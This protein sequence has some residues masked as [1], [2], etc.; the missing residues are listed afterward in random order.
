[1]TTSVPAAGKSPFAHLAQSKSK[2]SGPDDVGDEEEHED[3]THDDADEDDDDDGDDTDENGKKTKKS[4][5]VKKAEDDSDDKDEDKP[6]AS[7]ARRREKARIRTIVHSA[8]GK[9][10]PAAAL[11]L[12]LSS[13]MPRHAAVRLLARMGADIP[14]QGARGLRD[15]MAGV[16]MPEIGSDPSQNGG[17][18]PTSSSAAQAA[19]IIAAGRKARG[20]K[21]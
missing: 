21:V 18:G 13:A 12:A 6:D 2:R 17:G 10:L 14:T 7:A 20:E 9:R 3:N 11:N 1:M 4:K 16:D 15:R 8:A 5:K 19:L